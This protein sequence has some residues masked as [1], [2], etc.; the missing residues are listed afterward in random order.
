[1]G[2]KQRPDQF[3]FTVQ[4]DERKSD[5]CQAV[6]LIPVNSHHRDSVEIRPEPLFLGRVAG[7]SLAA[8]VCCTEKAG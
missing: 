6:R 7:A 5:C 4:S 3:L 8:E 1:M 2:G